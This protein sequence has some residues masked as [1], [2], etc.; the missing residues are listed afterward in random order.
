M[1]VRL[2]NIQFFKEDGAQAGVVVL[3]RMDDPVVT[4]GSYI[5]LRDGAADDRKLHELGT[6]AND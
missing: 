5:A 2:R 4:P 3:A 6:G 1:V